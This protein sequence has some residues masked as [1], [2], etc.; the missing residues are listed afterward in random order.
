[1]EKTRLD[2][3][4]ALLLKSRAKAQD[5]IDEGRVT[6][7]GKPAKKASMAVSDEDH[8][9]IAEKEDDFVSRAGGKLKAAVDAYK[10]DLKDKT[11][12]DIGASTGGFTQVCLNE[13]AKKVYALDVGHLQLADELANDPRVISMEGINARKLEADWFK[14]HPD[15]VC[16]DVSF[17]KASTILERVFEVIKP[18]S[19]AVLIK[20]QFETQKSALNRQGVLKDRKL[21]KKILEQYKSYVLQFYEVVKIMDSPVIGRSGNQEAILYAAKRRRND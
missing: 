18:E 14:D 8:I 16:M 4:L 21:R 1:M 10:I 6:V 9:E 15:F 20:P 19:L 5:A 3:H 11:V 7:N 2:K 13:G 12:L 17:I